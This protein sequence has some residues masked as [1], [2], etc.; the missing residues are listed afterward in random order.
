MRH[1]VLKPAASVLLLSTAL[2]SLLVPTAVAGDVKVYRWKDADGK[3]HFSDQKP[4]AAAEKLTIDTPAPK[5]NPELEQYRQ[6]TRVNL[7]TLDAE[8]AVAQREAKTHEII[9]AR[10]VRSCSA[11][12]NAMRVE[13]QVAILYTLDASGEMQHLTD[14]QRSN[15]KNDLHNQFQ[16]RCGGS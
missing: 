12:R 7:A 4:N 15:Y 3:Y 14:E 13:E 5:P 9:A 11:L 10:Q 6:Q 1:H 2:T 16:R 8:R